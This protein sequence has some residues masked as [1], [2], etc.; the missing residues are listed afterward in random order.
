MTKKTLFLHF[1]KKYLYFFILI[2]VFLF[3][4]IDIQAGTVVWNQKNDDFTVQ[5]ANETI[6][7]VLTQIEGKSNYIFVY[8]ENVKPYLN[9][10][11][12][13]SLSNKKINE[14]LD[15]IFARTDMK[16]R[17]SGRQITI[18]YAPSPIKVDKKPATRAG[19]ITGNVTDLNGEPLIGVSV[20]VKNEPTKGTITDI[21]GN[22]AILIP[23]TKETALTFSYIGYVQRVENITNQ[24]VIN[25]VLQE[26]VGQLDEVVVVAY[27]AQKRESVVGAI[28]SVQP[29]ALKTSTSRSLSNN[30]AGSLS[31]VLGVQRSGEPGY[32]NSSF[33][34]RGVSTFQDGFGN[35]LVLI[36]GIERSLNNIDIEEIESFSV[37]KDAA[38]SAVYG[39]RGANGV[40]LIN[41]KR[42]KV[43]APH[44]TV[45]SEFAVT[46]PVQLPEY[47]GAVQHM[48]ILDGI[49]LDN[50]YAPLYTERIAK[51]RLN[52]D[53]DLYPNVNWMDAVTKN[54]AD[55]QRVTLDVKGGTERLRYSF[56]AAYY[57]ENGIIERDKTNDWDSSIKLQRYNVRSNVDLN[58]TPTTLMRFN[59]GGYLQD[60]N[61]PPQDISF[62][63]QKAFV[64]VPFGYPTMYSSGQVAKTEEPNPWALATQTGYQ[65]TTSSR[66]ETLF[67][68]EQD[69]KFITPGLK[70]KVSFSFDRYSAGTVSRSK[71]PD[72]YS[73][74][75]GRNEEGDLIINL[76][77]AGSNFLG[78][79][80]SA[81]YGD[82]STYLEGSLT[83]QRTLNKLHGLEA[84][85]LVNRR[86]YDN[87]D[88]L[89]FRNQGLAGRTSYTYSGKYVGEFNF[90]Y[91]GSENLTAEKRYGFFPSGAIG[92]IVSEEPF[93]RNIRNTIPKLKLRT[94]YGQV[95]NS[96]LSGRRFAYLPTILNGSSDGVAGYS[97]GSNK[98]QSWAGMQ[99]GDFG[100]TNLVWETVNKLNLGLELGLFKQLIDIQIDVFD[101]R[102]S[103]IF[104]QRQSI[105]A[106]AGFSK[107]PWSNYG[108]VTNKGFET[109]VKFNHQFNKD[110]Y[111]SAFGN[112]TY[113]HNVI[114]E[115]DEAYALVG[116]SRAQTGH[117]VGQLFGYIAD[118]L[119][120]EDDFSDVST[121]QLKA[122]IPAHTLSPVRP[123]DIKYKDIDGNNVINAFDKA[124]MGGTNNPEIVYG[125]G[126]SMK[127]KDFDFGFMG[128]G[129]GRIYTILGQGNGAWLPGSGNGATGNILTNVDDRWTADNPRQDVFYPRLSM[130]T[131]VNNSQAS[132]WWLRDMSFFRIKNIELGYSFR[133][134]LLNKVSLSG[135]RLFL[136]GTNVLT[137]SDFK[138]WDPEVSST[139]GSSY[140]IMKS[141]S[142]GFEL[143]F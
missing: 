83:Y 59:I 48:E 61:A 12:N 127:Y 88:K 140:P 5:I 30:L 37:L 99:E 128:Q 139:Y 121:G 49:R 56:V 117:P 68:I 65:T 57:N 97:F 63:L 52:Y 28:T 134:N 29:A 10:K 115:I 124:P 85:L 74:A 102:R 70:A 133:K 90:G 45:K 111:V 50:G 66:I 17:M 51:T 21:N 122:E 20:V 105:P 72:Y 136:R 89:P 2:I 60:R 22:Y 143:T 114:T 46:Q 92:W 81:D 76:K 69:L 58:L 82:K 26:D 40:I 32:D 39:V 77:T 126:L 109:S 18:S 35:P 100:V 36:D 129:T 15:V 1:T 91:N 47:I 24:K 104:M 25:V 4:F 137:F 42:G 27:G 14:V 84:L 95:G 33:W 116:T 54:N 96:N 3:P 132:T 113:A 19:Q 43:S 120:T 79:S 67:S 138:L 94:S 41:T 16:Y 8:S 142:T 123:G 130:G 98:E 125:V 86:N 118:G 93:M 34:I 44:L 73:P 11:I 38:A 6:K 75:T 110:F 80:E 78:Y 103:S 119:F 87:G 7:D 107:T 71:S 101:E 62:I 23:D 108:K 31:G 112:F 53:S 131:N 13:C 106:T 135:A 9:I 141:F 64:T 55:N